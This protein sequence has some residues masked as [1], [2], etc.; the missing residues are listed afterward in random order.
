[1]KSVPVGLCVTV[2]A[3]HFNLTS[4]VCV[5]FFIGAAPKKRYRPLE[6]NSIIGS[7]RTAWSKVD[8]LVPWHKPLIRNPSKPVLKR[9]AHTLDH[10]KEARGHTRGP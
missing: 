5:L 8:P 1:M 7:V 9:G 4:G 6:P 2:F 10:F 3:L